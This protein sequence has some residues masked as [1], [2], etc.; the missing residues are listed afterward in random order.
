MA[1]LLVSSVFPITFTVLIWESNLLCSFLLCCQFYF[2]L[3]NSVC[4]NSSPRISSSSLRISLPISAYFFKLSPFC[5]YGSFSPCHAH[6]SLVP[7]W[8]VA[9]ICNFFLSV[10]QRVIGIFVFF[11]MASPFFLLLCSLILRLAWCFICSCCNVC[12]VVLLT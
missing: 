8:L 9:K 5:N 12:F 3:P 10:G 11:P 6:P 4:E 7:I 1:F 2:E